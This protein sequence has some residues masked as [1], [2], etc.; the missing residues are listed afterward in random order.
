MAIGT[1]RN[2]LLDFITTCETFSIEVEGKVEG[3]VEAKGR[4]VN[5]GDEVYGSE[6]F[7]GREGVNGREGANGVAN[8]WDQS[9]TIF[10]FRDDKAGHPGTLTSEIS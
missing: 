1:Y 10:C 8:V 7:N 5:G 6:E 9:W 2:F 3:K 4:G